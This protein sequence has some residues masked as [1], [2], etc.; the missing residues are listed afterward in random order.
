MK[1]IVLK[2]IPWMVVIPVS[3]FL[4][5]QI[6]RIALLFHSF[7]KI[8][9]IKI[10]DTGFFTVFNI[11]GICARLCKDFQKEI[12]WNYKNLYFHGCVFGNNK[13]IKLTGNSF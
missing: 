10:V 12:A 2:H 8:I 13:V 11:D 1:A 5:R 9:G 4:S 7:V 3:R 6:I